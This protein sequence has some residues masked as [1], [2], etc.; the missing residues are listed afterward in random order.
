MVRY[1]NLDQITLYLMRKFCSKL[2]AGVIWDNI[3]TLCHHMIYAETSMNFLLWDWLLILALRMATS[4]LR[5][6]QNLLIL[7]KFSR[8]CNW[9]FYIFS[10]IV[11]AEEFFPT[12]RYEIGTYRKLYLKPLTRQFLLWYYLF[13]AGQ[14]K[15]YPVLL[16]DGKN[17]EAYM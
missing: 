16:K 17:W 6:I 7:F 1:F 8:N 2:F 10:W 15:K 14:I 3:K 5:F 12:V 4:H 13:H 9:S 11:N